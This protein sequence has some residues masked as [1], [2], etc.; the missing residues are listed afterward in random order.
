VVAAEGDVAGALSRLDRLA[1]DASHGALAR[2][3][4]AAIQVAQRR[5][6]DA[7]PALEASFRAGVDEPAL[8]HALGVALAA[9]G[10]SKEALPH[11]Q[12]A[13]QRMPSLGVSHFYL[14]ICHAELGAMGSAQ[15]ALARAVEL[16]PDLEDA[17]EALARV[18]VSRGNTGVAQKL[19]DEA[20]RINKDSLLLRRY[21]AQ[22]LSDL[23]QAQGALAA[24][25]A[26]PETQRNAEDLANLAILS[27]AT[28]AMGP[29]LKHAQA[30]TRADGKLPAAFHALGLALEAQTPMDRAA[31]ID[32]YKKAIALGDPGGVTGTRLGFVMMESD[33]KAVLTE[34]VSVLNAAVER[35]GKA[36]GALLNLALALARL[37]DANAAK[38]TARSLLAD[39]RTGASEKEQAQR[40]I[41]TLG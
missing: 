4:R 18:E 33:D 29:A 16:Q 30:A 21:Q 17:W 35:S 15:Q 25:Q 5:Y 40:L 10:R 2:G 6:T 1:N 28:G 31:V 34:A 11:L 32:A 38:A 19:M 7:L 3:Y 24:I 12:N 23:G 8:R 13:T 27:M 22:L 39:P 41:K 26:I 14:G 36:P 9:Q 37:G 20:V